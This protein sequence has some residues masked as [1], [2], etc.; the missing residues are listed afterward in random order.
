MKVSWSVKAIH[1]FEKNILYLQKEFS[2]KEIKQFTAKTESIINKISL[3]PKLFRK[4]NYRN[5]HVVPIISA[6]TLFYRIVSDDEIE[7]VKFWN[8]YQN[9][10]SLLLNETP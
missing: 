5:I 3:N 4:T 8:N 1:D 10:E 9:P 6:V 2:Q 7:L